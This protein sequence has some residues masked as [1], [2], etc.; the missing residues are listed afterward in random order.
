MM[1]REG[2]S[3]MEL[4]E[5][6]NK[7]TCGLEHPQVFL[8]KYHEENSLNCLRDLEEARKKELRIEDVIEQSER[9][10]RK[11]KRLK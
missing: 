11:V 1:A 5:Q 10:G 3:I 7:K 8:S 9:M 4:F 2:L 6:N